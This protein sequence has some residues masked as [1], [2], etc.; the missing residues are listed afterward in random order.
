MLWGM[1]IQ[2]EGAP[3]GSFAPVDPID[4]P[5]PV[6]P[7]ELVRRGYDAVSSIYRA[8]DAE[9]GQYGP[10]IQ[11]LLQRLPD[12]GR[13]LDLGCGCGVP[14]SRAVAVTGR[15]VV[16]VDLSQ[17][18][19]DRARRL[20][21]G[22]TFMQADIADLEFADSSFDA[23]VAFYS[24]IHVPV[25]RQPALLES[26][27]RWLR[28]GGSFVATLGW[29]AWTGSESHW[30]G[31]DAAMWW[32]HADVETYREWLTAA[33]L[34]IDSVDFVAEGDGGHSLFWARRQLS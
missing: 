32:S 17:V 16:G 14:V 12:D 10:W 22:G 29:R 24:V 34:V 28:P 1:P 6:D 18:Q 26:V 9:E 20:V 19:V 25:D 21:P 2:H 8:D 31:S 30:L 3:T 11:T 27:S 4:P 13:V 5:D 7:V 23:V 15:H 33:G